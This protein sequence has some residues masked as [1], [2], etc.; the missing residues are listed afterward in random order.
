MTPNKESPDKSRYILNSGDLLGLGIAWGML[1]AVV[2][3]VLWIVV[4]LVI[5][6]VDAPDTLSA[7]GVGL[8]V[9]F[10]VPIALIPGAIGGLLAAAMLRLLM[11]FT[12]VTIVL[13]V[14]PGSLVGMAFGFLFLLI[15]LTLSPEGGC[16]ST[17]CW[18]E[19][20]LLYVGIP[21]FGGV[22]HGWQMA[23]W[24]QKREV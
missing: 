14:L 6:W 23:R 17:S 11:C 19:V 3:T 10:G 9:A 15:A 8:T 2:S 24:L 5:N 4:T 21:T 16:H 13:G 18:I 22:W 7:R 20:I 1:A 12:R